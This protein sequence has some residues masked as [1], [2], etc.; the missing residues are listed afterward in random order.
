[1]GLMEKSKGRKETRWIDGGR[2][3]R[4]GHQRP[5]DRSLARDEGKRERKPLNLST[6]RLLKDLP[7]MWVS[8]VNHFIFFLSFSL[9][10][11]LYFLSFFLF[12]PS[13]SHSSDVV[14]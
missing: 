11:S 12:N 1:M 10:L 2:D 4:R 5:N 3:E 8:N 14:N 7:P 6:E 9:S 13:F